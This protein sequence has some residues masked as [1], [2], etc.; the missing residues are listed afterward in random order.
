MHRY[1]KKPIEIGR[2]QRHAM[3]YFYDHRAGRFTVSKP[4]ERRRACGLH[5]RRSGVARLRG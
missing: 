3:E 5:R 4:V 2:L 1:N